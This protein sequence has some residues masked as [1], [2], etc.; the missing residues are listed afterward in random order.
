MTDHL[1]QPTT[2]LTVVV[3]EL[4]NACADLKLSLAASNSYLRLLAPVP[5]RVAHKTRDG[6][7]L[8][9]FEDEGRRT[10]AAVAT[11]IIDVQRMLDQLR[12]VA[13]IRLVD[14]AFAPEVAA[15]LEPLISEVCDLWL[16]HL[17]LTECADALLVVHPRL[18]LL[19][20]KVAADLAVV[21]V[22]IGGS[23]SPMP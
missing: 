15:A 20:H 16:A 22:A 12:R 5:S 19:F 17:R 21:N 3:D 18:C 1:T 6:R 11:Q 9:S 2:W 14:G 7:A 10:V 8:A 23:F 4:T 13:H